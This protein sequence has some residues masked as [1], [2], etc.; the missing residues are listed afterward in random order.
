MRA[1][2]ERM[3]TFGSYADLTHGRV[4]YQLDG[5]ANAPTVVLVH[6][7]AGRLHIWD[8]NYQ[9]LVD[10]GFRVLRFDLYGRGL[11]DR[12]RQPHTAD[13]FV[14]QLREM[15]DHVGMREPVHL[16]GLS[17]G[18]AV[19]TR[20]ATA[21]PEAVA[22]MAWVCSFAFP[23]PRDLV[24]SLTRMPLL[25]EALMGG[26]GGAVLRR[27]TQRAMFDPKADAD[28]HRWFTAPVSIRGSK[29]AVLK[30]MRHF[31]SEDHSEHFRK[32]GELSVPKTL[33]WGR[34]DRILP[35]DY[36]EKVRNL[37]PSAGFTVFESS[38]HLP[39]YEEAEK[40]NSLITNHFNQEPYIEYRG[41]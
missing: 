27:A 17:M 2:L 3:R 11:S 12:V 26:I 33:V 31:L 25:G 1:E 36:G 9:H 23:R 24:A 22:S 5:P 38:G 30:S 4:R 19:I 16:A 18:G 10:N 13:L 21:H 41:V 34:H 35:F 7:L 20:F 40:F 15:L 29:R 14:L 32:A 37:I 8:R 6:G 28:I 39:Q